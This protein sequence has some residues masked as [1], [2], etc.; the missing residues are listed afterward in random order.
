MIYCQHCG[1]KYMH[2]FYITESN[3]IYIYI[4][5]YSP[6]YVLLLLWNCNIEINNRTLP[7][8]QGLSCAPIWIVGAGLIYSFC[9]VW[10]W[11]VISKDSCNQKLGLKYMVRKTLSY[12]FIKLRIELSTGS[13]PLIPLVMLTTQ[14]DAHQWWSPVILIHKMTSSNWNI[15]PRYWSF[16][17]GIHH[18]PVNSPHKDQWRGALIFSFIS[19]WTN[20][21]THN[22]EAGDLRRHR[23]QYDVIVIISR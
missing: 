1:L 5:F 14:S 3:H 18:W 10:H 20:S 12:F 22:G 8:L 21:S 23:T 17:R 19:A 11:T 2:G 9:L 7:L 15:F 4:L 16:V 13:K 6:I